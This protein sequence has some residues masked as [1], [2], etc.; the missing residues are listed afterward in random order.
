MAIVPIA[1]LGDFRRG[2]DFFREQ[3]NILAA[4]KNKDVTE[5]YFLDW[6]RVLGEDD[7]IDTLEITTTGNVSVAASGSTGSLV[8]FSLS[9]S[10]GEVKVKIVS[11]LTDRIL[12]QTLRFIDTRV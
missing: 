9:G 11:L 8:N 3:D 1:F 12:I 10:D 7:S 2:N 6:T 4:Y 5:S